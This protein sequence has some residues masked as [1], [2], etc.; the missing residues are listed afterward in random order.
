MDPDH[1]FSAWTPPTW[2]SIETEVA[3]SDFS[4]T[5]GGF[6]YQQEQVTLGA[7]PQDLAS[8]ALVIQVDPL[9]TS[10]AQEFWC[11]K[12][13]PKP[14]ATIQGVSVT[15]TQLSDGRQKWEIVTASAHYLIQPLAANAATSRR[16]V[17]AI[18][19]SFVPASRRPLR[20]PG[21]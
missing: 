10:K 12:S 15:H 19:A 16:D 2:K 3:Q 8:V 21:A 5:Q 20:C 6:V 11:A 7:A 17:E 13:L 4:P 1:S 18:V 14:N 9:A